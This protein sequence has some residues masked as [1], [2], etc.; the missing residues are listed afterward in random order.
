MDRAATHLRRAELAAAARGVDAVKRIIDLFAN[1][2]K[3]GEIVW[4][5]RGRD[6]LQYIEEHFHTRD[7]ALAFMEGLRRGFEL[8]R[9]AK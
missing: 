5:V 9:D 7:E 6:E 8:G 4:S 3:H 2:D 1:P